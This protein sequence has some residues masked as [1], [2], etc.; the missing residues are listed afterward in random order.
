MYILVYFIEID[1]DKKRVSLSIRALLPEEPAVEETAEEV[2]E[3][4]EVVAEESVAE[5]VASSVAVEETA[6]VEE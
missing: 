6:T 4:A 1:Q 5:E 3:V 2:V